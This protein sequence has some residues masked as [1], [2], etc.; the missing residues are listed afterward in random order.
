MMQNSC[1]ITVQHSLRLTIDISAHVKDNIFMQKV[2][3]G[4]KNIF[5]AFKVKLLNL[6]IGA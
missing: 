5:I 4:E 1:Y 6:H 3:E 2:A